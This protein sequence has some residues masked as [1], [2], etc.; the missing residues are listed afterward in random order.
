MDK[1]REKSPSEI[2]LERKLMAP[3]KEKFDE[4]TPISKFETFREKA[5]EMINF[6]LNEDNGSRRMINHEEIDKMKKSMFKEENTSPKLSANF[7]KRMNAK[8]FK[9]KWDMSDL[10]KTEISTQAEF[11][12]IKELMIKQNSSLENTIEN[13]R[14]I[15]KPLNSIRGS[16]NK[17]YLNEQVSEIEGVSTNLLI[18]IEGIV[19][20]F[21]EVLRLIEQLGKIYTLEKN[22]L[23]SVMQEEKEAALSKAKEKYE[24]QLK[25]LTEHN[26]ELSLSTKGKISEE[27]HKDKILE[28]EAKIKSVAEACNENIE[29][30]KR[31]SAEINKLQS[32]IIK[33]N[34]EID[35]LHSD[36]KNFQAI[37]KSQESIDSS[38]TANLKAEISYLNDMLSQSQKQLESSRK[39]DNGKLSKLELTREREVERLKSDIIMLQSQLE[40]SVNHMRKTDDLGRA[41]NKD[42]QREIKKLSDENKNIKKRYREEV[43]SL[44]R[45]LQE[46]DR[47]LHLDR[48]KLI[49]EIDVREEWKRLHLELEEKDRQLY[50]ERERLMAEIDK[51][52]EI[53][54]KQKIEWAEICDNLSLEIK[55]LKEK[56]YESCEN[57]RRL[58]EELDR[59]R[60]NKMQGEISFK[61]QKEG[62]RD[63]L[64]DKTLEV[65]K[66]WEIVQEL[67]Q[68][69]ITK[70]KIDY[71]DIRSLMN[72]KGLVKRAKKGQKSI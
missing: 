5:K 36:I 58:L 49:N 44:Q 38:Q 56:L 60:A 71:N 62:F 50:S 27:E 43:E 8:K 47:L 48:E 54:N 42:L 28:L 59:S 33:Q 17:D 52:E 61:T 22:E 57:N 19:L 67:Q 32:T 30:S 10:Y 6:H 39:S 20:A 35:H 45:E 34:E 55:Q 1:V 14:K 64:K 9:E 21:H 18:G 37:I 23:K 68:I 31:K 53:K 29:N 25:A 69:C 7:K 51:K 46:K 63:K 12:K 40:E 70:G 66:F 65:K 3:Y 26:K 72:I 4:E 41:E 11:L 2:I 15:K 24:N 13:I 16:N